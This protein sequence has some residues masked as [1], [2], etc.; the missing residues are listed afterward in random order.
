MTC[1]QL[2]PVSSS[3]CSLG[4]HRCLCTCHS[5]GFA[6]H[7]LF[8]SRLA[9]SIR[10]G[11]PTPRSTCYRRIRIVRNSNRNKRIWERS[12]G[13]RREVVH[14]EKAKIQKICLC[15]SMAQKLP[16]QAL[17]QLHAVSDIFA[18]LCTCRAQRSY[19]E[20]Y[21]QAKEMSGQ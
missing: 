21:Q 14:S 6:I 3:R 4:I 12:D 1:T 7:N 15:Q 2:G 13:C 16:S 20:D 18:N 11:D 19:D 17:L 10:C 8:E 9:K 5:S